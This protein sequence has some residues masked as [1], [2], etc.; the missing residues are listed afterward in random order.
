MK[1]ILKYLFISTIIYFGINAIRIYQFSKITSN[2][3]CDVALVLGAGT[4]NGKLS[5]VF[6]ERINHGIKLYKQRKVKQIIFTGGFGKGESISDSQVAKDYAIINGVP[7]KDIFIEEKS[8]YTIQN[9]QEA[10]LIIDSLQFENCLIVSDPLHMKR[11]IDLA[12]KL[13]ID[14]FPSPT[15][16]SMYKSKKIKFKFLMYETL[17]F[18]AGELTGQN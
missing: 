9:L 3:T 14:C 17:F 1:K 12:K 11:S 15:S 5:A 16:T 4:N 18:T 2:K 7:E 8:E 6:K 10:K 13:G